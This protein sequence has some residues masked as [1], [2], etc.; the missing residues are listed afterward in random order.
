[1]HNP[2]FFKS[3]IFLGKYAIQWPLIK[4]IQLFFIENF[5]NC[6]EKGLLYILLARMV[7]MWHFCFSISQ[8]I[9]FFATI[10][11]PTLH[12]RGLCIDGKK[13]WQDPRYQIC[14]IFSTKNNQKFFLVWYH[15]FVATNI[16]SVITLLIMPNKVVRHYVQNI[17]N[18]CSHDGSVIFWSVF[19][20][21]Q[22]KPKNH[23]W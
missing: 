21:L 6:N 5:N 13:I 18:Q 3:T 15:S 10:A 7:P 12:T 1:M 4:D 16:S 9:T 2:L 14:D 23:W 20:D 22:F 17:F 19:E 8:N 11:T